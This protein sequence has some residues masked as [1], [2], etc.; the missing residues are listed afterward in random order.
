MVQDL[1]EEL[2]SAHRLALAY[3]P[4]SSQRQFLAVFALDARLA[5]IVRKRNEAVLAQIRIAWWR[6]TLR[7]NKADWP[8]GDLVLAALNEWDEVSDVSG[9]TDGW[10]F[11]L[12]EILSQDAIRSFADGRARAMVAIARALRI[13][14]QAAV[15]TA[16]R[17]WALADLS[18]NVF[19]AGERQQIMTLVE[20]LGPVPPLPRRL[21]PLAILAQL[22]AR[23]LKS[24]GGA[25][26]DGPGS[27][28]CALRVGLFGR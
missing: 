11:M 4:A 13:S 23:A 22:G 24:G 21:R 17:Y 18:A 8:K 2:P 9:L 1:V 3:A 25:L 14:D 12:H 15:D 27:V 5:K 19:D 16:A 10:E 6:E 26:L 20:A 28:F 7:K